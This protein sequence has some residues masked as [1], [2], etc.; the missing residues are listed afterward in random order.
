MSDELTD[1]LHL[2]LADTWQATQIGWCWLLQGRSESNEETHQSPT[3]IKVCCSTAGSSSSE[4]SVKEKVAYLISTNCPSNKY[5]RMGTIDQTIR[6]VQ[7]R[8]DYI[9][10][11]KCFLA[12]DTEEDPLID[13]L[14]S[15]NDQFDEWAYQ[16]IWS[17]AKAFQILYL[18]LGDRWSQIE[19]GFQKLGKRYPGFQIEINNSHDFFMAL[20]QETADL[21]I[22]KCY[23]SFFED[24]TSGFGRLVTLKR[25]EIGKMIAPKNLANKGS[26]HQKREITDDEKSELRKLTKPRTSGG[27]STFTKLEIV[28]NFLA[29]RDPWLLEQMERYKAC[30]DG[31]WAQ[32]QA[33]TH[34][35]ELK[36]NRLSETWWRGVRRINQRSQYRK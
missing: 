1:F 18:V 5:F 27:L 29:Q 3:P 19:Q 21:E 14:N 15:E 22:K 34:K 11:A 33:A 25:R 30:L 24:R 6:W 9:G 13:R 4:A 17:Y 10:I 32:E 2:D 31:I 28:W 16:H 35:P 23:E 36:H 7:L 20:V 26:L 12:L 8:S